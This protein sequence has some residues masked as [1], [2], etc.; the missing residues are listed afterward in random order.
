ESRDR[1]LLSLRE[2]RPVLP[3]ITIALTATTTAWGSGHGTRGRPER[4]SP[5]RYFRPAPMT[6]DPT[7]SSIPLSTVRPRRRQPSGL[8]HGGRETGIARTAPTVS[9]V[10]KWESGSG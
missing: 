5:R 8:S 2:S 4:P 7:S 3:F 6:T 1:P 10:R 9:G